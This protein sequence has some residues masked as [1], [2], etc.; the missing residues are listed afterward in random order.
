MMKNWKTKVLSTAL[1]LS[2]LVPSAAF[3]AGTVTGAGEVPAK[4]GFAHHQPFNEEKRQEMDNQLLDL[5]GKYTPE[6]LV[7][8]KNALAERD[9]LVNDLKEKRPVDKQRP[10]LSSE[11][12][13]KLQ[14]IRED[15]QNGKLTPEQAREELK[16]LGIE[17]FRS[18]PGIPGD[19][20]GQ[21]P[22]LSAELKEKLQSIREDVQNGKLTPEQAK[23]EMQK[24][25]LKGK[26]GIFGDNLMVQL[27]EAVDANDETKIKELLPQLLEQMVERNQALAD[28]LAE[29]N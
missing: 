3:A 8:W 9:Q 7:D 22:E 16:N 29:S 12:K 2:V 28:R 20:V 18:Q 24:L 19:E 21:R 10:E 15:V 4:K 14:S 5:V 11:L 1:A 23:E 27:K 26:P 25:G 6:S 13:E 17:K